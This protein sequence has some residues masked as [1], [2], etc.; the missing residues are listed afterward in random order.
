[1]A[2][3]KTE[4]LGV[5]KSLQLSSFFLEKERERGGGGGGGGGVREREEK[6]ERRRGEKLADTQV[7]AVGKPE[8]LRV[9]KNLQVSSFERVRER[10]RGGGEGVEGRQTDKWIEG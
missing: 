1:M 3:S 5:M 8:V 4:V 9:M 7:V 10:E 2:I 6:R